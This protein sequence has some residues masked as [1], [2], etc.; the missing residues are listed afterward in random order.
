MNTDC[1]MPAF[2]TWSEPV[3][4]KTHRCCECHAPILKGEKHYRVTGKWDGDVST[5]RQHLVCM[6]ACMLIR[7]EFGGDCIAFGSLLEEFSEMR[8]DGWYPT[9]EKYDEAWKRLRHLIAVIKVRIRK[10]ERAAA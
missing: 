2:Y 10:A 7:D 8:F 3:A 5:L 6:E 1:E 9:Q 4:R